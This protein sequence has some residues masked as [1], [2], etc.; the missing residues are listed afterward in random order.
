MPK[1]AV[2]TLN[3]MTLR[4]TLLPSVLMHSGIVVLFVLFEWKISYHGL[5]SRAY[6]TIQAAAAQ[7]SPP[8]VVP[9]P[10]GVPPSIA[11]PAAMD[12][13]WSNELK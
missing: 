2:L 13:N 9:G 4:T 8:P 6:T 5:F 10:S 3:C 11:I 12:V 7:P 1:L